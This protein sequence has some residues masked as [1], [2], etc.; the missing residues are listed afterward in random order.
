MA[1]SVVDHSSK[2]GL[3]PPDDR[4]KLAV[5]ELLT[6]HRDVR[7]GVQIAVSLIEYGEV[8]QTMNDRMS[9]VTHDDAIISASRSDVSPKRCHGSL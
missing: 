4:V 2:P 3:A 7:I 5:G 1:Q 8:G 6:H 9:A